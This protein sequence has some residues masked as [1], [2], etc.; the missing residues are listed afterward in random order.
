MLVACTH[1]DIAPVNR[2]PLVA[3]EHGAAIVEVN[4]E[5][6]LYTDRITDYFLQGSAGEV[7]SDLVGEVEAILKTTPNDSHMLSP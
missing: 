6:S 2:M 4:R 1:G 3:K 7:L 5:R